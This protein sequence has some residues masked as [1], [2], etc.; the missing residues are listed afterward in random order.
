[1]SLN[2]SRIERSFSTTEVQDLTTAFGA[3]EQVFDFHQGASPQDMV[4]MLRVGTNNRRFV[5]EI[6][7]AIDDYDWLLPGYVTKQQF[8]LGYELWFQLDDMEAY[9]ESLLNRVTQTKLIAGH[10]LM[11]DSLDVYGNM[12]QA[13][14]RGVSGVVPYLISAER[15]FELNGPPTANQDGE[16]ENPS[17]QSDNDPAPTA[18]QDQGNGPSDDSPNSPAPATPQDS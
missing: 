11:R 12:Q 5:Q 7:I 18:A 14:H 3:V 16:A 4:R 1:M 9:L 13:V 6:K 2:T 8:D 10:H 15:R 17:T